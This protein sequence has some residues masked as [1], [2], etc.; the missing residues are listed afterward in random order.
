MGRK[1]EWYMDYAVHAFV[2]YALLGRPTREEYEKRLTDRVYAEYALLPPNEILARAEAAREKCKRAAE[3]IEAVNAML[4]EL[5]RTGQSYVIKAVEN[6]YFTAPT[7]KPPQGAIKLRV[8]KSAM[9][10][11]AS[12]RTVERW[13][14]YAK[15]L[16]CQKR[17]LNT[18]TDEDVW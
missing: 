2:W 16:F 12:E 8:T 6:V 10:F 1:K 17:G 3:D 9:D 7:G 14:K 4:D 11:P 18:G 15:L 13:L 5:R